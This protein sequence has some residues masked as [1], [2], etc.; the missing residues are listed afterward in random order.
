MDFLLWVWEMAPDAER[1]RGVMPRAYQYLR[2]EL[3]S[4]SSAVERWKTI[5]HRAKVFTTSHRRWEAIEGNEKVFL[6]DLNHPSIQKVTANL[7][8]ATPGHLGAEMAEQIATAKLLSLNLLSTRFSVEIRPEVQL[9]VPEHWQQGFDFI[10]KRLLDQL[11]NSDNEEEDAKSPAETG[12]TLLQLSRWQSIHTIVY[13]RGVEVHLA[14][15][16]AALRDKTVAVSGEP[17]DFAKELC[18]V[19]CDFWG[20]RRRHDLPEILPELAIR[21]TEISNQD[22]VATW[23][24]NNSEESEE[25]PKEVAKEQPA[26]EPEEEPHVKPVRKS[27]GESEEKTEEQP[28]HTNR[29]GKGHFQQSQV[30][31]APNSE[32]TSSGTGTGKPTKPTHNGETHNPR[33]KRNRMLSYVVPQGAVNE[34]PPDTA[35]AERRRQIDETGMKRVKEHEEA[36]NREPEIM[37]HFNEGFDIKSYENGKL[38]RYIEVKSLSGDWDIDNVKMTHTQ[39][40]YA[41]EVGDRYWLYVVERAE[42]ENYLIHQIQNP[43]K[44]VT[45]FIFDYMWQALED[46]DEPLDS[47]LQV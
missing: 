12:G 39:F 45:S 29:A 13:D 24:S 37:P 6:D 42:Q 34:D 20:L 7:E 35:S 5:S 33:P 38:V 30:P 25:E 27:E 28:P 41:T 8:L 46:A 23:I 3:S 44:K 10:Q 16:L 4:N 47:Q 11:S 40:E 31:G 22:L 18:R 9:P 1:V 17:R 43:A 2:E 14:P 15:S 36:A 26:R 32:T 19:L 21:V